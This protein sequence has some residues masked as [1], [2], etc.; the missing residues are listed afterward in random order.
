MCCQRARQIN[1]VYKRPPG[2]QYP[3]ET[4]T[5]AIV[6]QKAL[7]LCCLSIFQTVHNIA[8][9]VNHNYVVSCSAQALSTSL[10]TL[11]CQSHITL[12]HTFIKVWHCCETKSPVIF[13]T[14]RAQIH[15]FSPL[16]CCSIKTSSNGYWSFFL[17]LASAE[18]LDINWWTYAS[19]KHSWLKVN[20]KAGSL[21]QSKLQPSCPSYHH[22]H[23]YDV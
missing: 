20:Q 8:T 21:G 6:D 17:F 15:N 19:L 4:L 9:G 12:S 16:N 13:Q 11:I 10:S 5:H 22:M 3:T 18:D 7:C 14:Q 1:P 2:N 23:L